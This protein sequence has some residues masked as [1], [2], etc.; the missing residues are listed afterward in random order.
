MITLRFRRFTVHGLAAAL[1]LSL[2]VHVALLAMGLA[3][4]PLS[5]T[6]P[7]AELDVT[8]VSAR[9]LE[10][11][12]VA[13]ELAQASLDGG[14]NID[15]GAARATAPR[16][17]MPQ[18]RSQPS[19]VPAASRAAARVESARDSRPV[20][21]S[22]A[23]PLLPSRS[24]GP[25]PAVVAERPDEASNA[26]S[27]AAAPVSGG[28]LA[29]RV[30]LA[31]RDDARLA[32]DL[33]HYESAPRRRFVGA[34]ARELRFALYLD[35]WREKIERMGTT[36]YPADARGRIYGNLRLT[37]AIRAD[38]TIESLEFD[39][40]SGRIELDQAAERIVRM[41]A[42]F[43]PLPP[44]VRRDTDVLVITRTWFFEPGDTLRSE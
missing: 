11:P 13:R 22:E 14:G 10:A 17:A 36:H 33:Q 3:A 19:T 43:A 2:V 8:L 38:G 9:S 27:P 28:D 25:A 15:E 5:V 32:R 26:P 4:S 39:R 34:Q 42:P 40:R 41:G 1:L 31:V 12:V 6:A 30:L 16:A 37:V 7:P 20:L 29:A 18:A 21:P 23:T 35:Q 44:E 24:T